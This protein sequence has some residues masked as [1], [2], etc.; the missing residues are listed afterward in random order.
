MSLLSHQ[1][2]LANHVSVFKIPPGEISLSKW[3][4][5]PENVVWQGHLRLLEQEV[6]DSSSSAPLQGLR[7]KLELYNHEKLT[8]VLEDFVEVENDTQWAEVWYNPFK[9]S[10]LH[11]KI[12]NDG[13]DTIQVTPQSSSYYKIITQLPGSGYHPLNLENEGANSESATGSERKGGVLQIAL[14]LKFDDKFTA[15]LFSEALATYRRRFRNV[16]DKNLYDK[17]LLTLQRKIMEGLR[18][19][20]EDLREATPMSDFEDDEFGNFVGSSYD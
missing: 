8:Q 11:Y 10:E 14:G 7:L 13:E 3:N 17:H 6:E 9:E 12:A 19:Q 16:Q 18:I 5:A 4:A 2:F 1:I 15:I 20:E